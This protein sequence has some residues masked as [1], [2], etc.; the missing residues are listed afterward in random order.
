MRRILKIKNKK[1]C[2]LA[3][4]L[5]SHDGCCN[6]MVFHVLKTL[7]TT[8]SNWVVATFP[9]FVYFVKTLR[10]AS[11]LCHDLRLLN[12]TIAWCFIS[13]KTLYVAH[14]LC[15]RFH[16]WKMQD[17]VSSGLNI[18]LVFSLLKSIW[19]QSLS[20]PILCKSNQ[21]GMLFL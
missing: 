20:L 16:I 15:P 21:V 18:I 6:G 11:F 9:G 7:Y 5:F 8:I 12:A 10:M 3:H 17:S 14:P 2:V 1:S 19:V 13:V 4:P